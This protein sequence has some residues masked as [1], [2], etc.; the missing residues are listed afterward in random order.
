M[1]QSI[2]VTKYAEFSQNLKDSS[3]FGFPYFSKIN[4]K[5]SKSLLLKNLDQYNLIP[6]IVGITLFESDILTISLHGHLNKSN[7][8]YI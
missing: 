8:F 6:I 4:V 1:M 5:V 2:E 3:F 7:T